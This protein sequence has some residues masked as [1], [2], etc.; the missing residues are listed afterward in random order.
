MTAP[1]VFAKDA[2]LSLNNNKLSDHNRG[3]LTVNNERI[4]TSKRMANG[5]LRKY[6][7]A[8]KRKFSVSWTDLPST[9]TNTVDGFWGGREIINFCRAQA[10]AVT[11]KLTHG[12]SASET[13]TVVISSFNHDIKKRGAYDFWDISIEL[14]EV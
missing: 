7:V 9:V 13:F 1:L 3:E 11:L 5:K 12:D 2:L 8:D 10:G 14:E 4:E 6:V